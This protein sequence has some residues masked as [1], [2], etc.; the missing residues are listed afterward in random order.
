[1]SVTIQKAAIILSLATTAPGCTIVAPCEDV[2]RPAI[3]LIVLDLATQGPLGSDS[4]VVV[5]ADGSYSD[6]IRFTNVRP[7]PVT[8]LQLAHERPGL[9]DIRISAAGYE[10]WARNDIRVRGG[11]CH[12]NTVDVTA[13]LRR[14]PS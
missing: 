2:E 12:V 3:A 8:H 10:T 1:V 5:T 7:D 13:L 11:R 4:I 9:Y 6:T 14:T